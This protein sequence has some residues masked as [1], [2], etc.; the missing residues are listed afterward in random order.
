[1]QDASILL[2]YDV[3]FVRDGVKQQRHLVLCNNVVAVVDDGTVIRANPA[4]INST[5]VSYTSAAP[6]TP[7][8]VTE[9]LAV[10]HSPH[11]AHEKRKL[12]EAHSN[13]QLMQLRHVPALGLCLEVGVIAKGFIPANETLL[14]ESILV[15]GRHVHVLVS[16]CWAV[17]A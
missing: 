16:S 6:A 13:I 9:L 5:A 4:L 14:P 1:M 15:D 12:K 10:A 8:D 11:F 3:W 2:E 17:A 7:E